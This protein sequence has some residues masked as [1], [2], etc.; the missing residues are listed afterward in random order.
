MCRH[1]RNQRGLQGTLGSALTYLS[2][3]PYA[4]N[5]A[6]IQSHTETFFDDC[7]YCCVMMSYGREQG[8]GAM[9]KGAREGMKRQE[10]ISKTNNG[11]KM[12]PAS[13]TGRVIAPSPPDQQEGPSSSG[14]LLCCCHSNKMAMTYWNHQ[15]IL[16]GH[17]HHHY[18][19]RANMV[20]S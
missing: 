3:P 12:A 7:R 14:R 1:K 20:R 4:Y 15:A 17:Y 13:N 8:R 10:R 2:P 6:D 5:Q 19:R 18:H 9:I 11:T 16:R